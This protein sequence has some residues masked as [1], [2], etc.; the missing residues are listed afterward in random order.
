MTSPMAEQGRLHRERRARQKPVPRPT[1]AAAS[2]LSA[3][4]PPA[5]QAASNHLLSDPPFQPGDPALTVARG[6][7]Y[8]SPDTAGRTT[9][10]PGEDDVAAALHRLEPAGRL[11]GRR[12]GA[13]RRQRALQHPGAQRR[14]DQGGTRAA[15]VEIIPEHGGPGLRP[16]VKQG[17]GPIL[18]RANR[19]ARAGSRPRGPSRR[20]YYGSYNENA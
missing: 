5:K 14:R 20:I 1:P 15:G 11:L 17:E 9:R 6:Q 12:C 10:P 3:V 7:F 13:P 8:P 18:A 19:A 2:L 16:R 4:T